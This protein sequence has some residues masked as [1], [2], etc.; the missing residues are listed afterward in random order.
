MARL[1]Q[2][3]MHSRKKPSPVAAAAA[4]PLLLMC[5][6]FAATAMAASSSAAAAAASFVEPSDADT[7][8]TCFEVGGC[9]NTG[10]AIRCRDLGH[11]PAGSACRT[12]DTAIYCCCGVGRDTPPSVA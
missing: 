8:S 9:N 3:A 6:L 10:C 12:R 7:Y 4:V 2:L 1:L 5:L 11:N